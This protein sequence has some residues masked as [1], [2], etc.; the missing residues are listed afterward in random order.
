MT[1]KKICVTVKKYDVEFCSKEVIKISE[2]HIQVI[3]RFLLIAVCSFLI[4]LNRGMMNQFAGIKTHMFVGIGA[5]LSFLVPYLFYAEHT[6]LTADP[7]RLS[8]Q[9]ISGIGFLGAGTIIKSGQSI[10]GLTTAAGL[11]ATA[12]IAIA[13][14]SG[15]MI[16]SM[17]AVVLVLV[18]LIFGNRIN[19]T[20][21][22]STLSLIITLKGMESNLDTVNEFMKSNLTLQKDYIILEYIKDGNDSIALVRYD[23][24]HRQC[25]LTIN[26][27]MKHLS[28]FE[29]I[30]KI[31]LQ[32]E[33]QKL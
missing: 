30:Q 31:D 27:I 15:A 21:K 19:I 18:F 6:T 33:L 29:Y 14:A 25:G 22:Y 32:T 4:G 26:E 23:I 10:K 2:I 3:F 13:M 7:F 5:G 8:A 20:R 9:V 1:S 17:T 11:W 24:V 28:S 12:I 16:L